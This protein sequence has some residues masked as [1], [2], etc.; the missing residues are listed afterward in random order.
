[1]A[2]KN[3]IN[4]VSLVV[5]I[6]I[7]FPFATAHLDAGEDKVSNGYL[8]DFGY[9]PEK[10]ATND[11]VSLSLEIYEEETNALIVPSSVD[12]KISLNDETIFESSLQPDSGQILLKEKFLQG[13]DYNIEAVFYSEDEQLVQESFN[14]NVDDNNVDPTLRKY[15]D[16]FGTTPFFTEIIIIVLAIIGIF[17]LGR[18]EKKKEK[19]EKL[20]KKSNKKSRKRTHLLTIILLSSLFLITSL[21]FV[22]A[23]EG[24]IGE[25]DWAKPSIYI[26]ISGAL[27]LILCIIAI[28]A[29]Q[30]LHNKG[31]HFIFWLIVI[32]VTLSSIYLASYTVYENVISESKGP[33]HWHAD[34]QIWACG[35]RLDL[36]NPNFPS[37]KIGSPLF[38]EHDD[39]R[40][41]TEGTVLRL[42]DVDLGSYF[43]VIGGKLADG[44]LSYPTEDNG[45]ATYQD[46]DACSDNLPGT[47]KVYING[48]RIDDYENYL[49]YPDPLVPPGDC[50]IVIFDETSDDTTSLLCESW[51]VSGWN[52]DNYKDKREDVSI[53]GYSWE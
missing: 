45:L 41:H 7:L 51:E 22:S 50:V 3:I 46:G 2:D 10:P 13:G 30:N 31:K 26:I 43:E 47:L 35:E 32:V 19:E 53:G 42:E 11:L 49:Y 15:N 17:V 18:I 9:S 52:Y 36:I 20:K 24:S 37:N 23:Q 5:S 29:G 48:E 33:I 39:D 1:M 25:I 6:L 21:T 28:V 38:H 14:F 40:I 16:L 27:V 8:I 44:T 4:C 12:I 34:Y